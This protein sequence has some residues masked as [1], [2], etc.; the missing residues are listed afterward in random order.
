MTSF[1]LCRRVSYRSAPSYA[2]CPRVV[3]GGGPAQGCRDDRA[4]HC[5]DN[6][7]GGRLRRA[8]GHHPGGRR[9]IERESAAM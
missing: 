1:S 9:P 4:D 3:G 7:G 6:G 5:A 8:Q 2:S